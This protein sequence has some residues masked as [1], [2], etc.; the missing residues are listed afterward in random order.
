MPSTRQY[1]WCRAWPWFLP[2][3]PFEEV[4]LLE[5]EPLKTA[6]AMLAANWL[7]DHPELAVERR[8]QGGRFAAQIAASS[9]T[10][11][12]AP[13]SPRQGARRAP[14]TSA[15]E[16]VAVLAGWA[17]RPWGLVIQRVGTGEAIYPRACEFFHQTDVQ[18]VADAILEALRTQRPCVPGKSFGSVDALLRYGKISAESLS[19]A[20]RALATR[21]I[22]RLVRGR[23]LHQ[24]WARAI[25]HEAVQLELLVRDEL[26]IPLESS[27]P[28]A[29]SDRS[30]PTTP[31]AEPAPE[32]MNLHVA[33]A[34]ESYQ[35]AVTAQP[36]LLDHG[37]RNYRGTYAFLQSAIEGE[38]YQYAAGDLPSLGTWE[39]NV[40][41]GLAYGAPP[42]SS[43][44][45]GREHGSSIVDEGQV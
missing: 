38:R 17:K 30:Q 43:S 35:W 36:S 44:R 13:D 12:G 40:R 18:D 42:G 37:K 31:T 22:E 20:E 6:L 19:V 33:A 32:A 5:G 16:K 26:G 27:A 3:F 7:R 25:A 8:E 15:F 21:A 24:D 45:A 9:M 41:A 14:T 34:L 1:L 11:P 2:A 10:L 23:D 4:E 29:R 39:R 28:D